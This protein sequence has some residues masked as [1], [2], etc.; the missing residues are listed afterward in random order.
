MSKERWVIETTAEDHVVAIRVGKGNIVHKGLVLAEE[1]DWGHT[2]NGA[3]V[4]DAILQGV[5]I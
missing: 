5:N 3:C 2:E 1:Q 4:L